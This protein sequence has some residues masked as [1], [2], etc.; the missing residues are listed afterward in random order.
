MTLSVVTSD[1]S[2]E[3]VEGFVLQGAQSRGKSDEH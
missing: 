3:N 2:R 1:T